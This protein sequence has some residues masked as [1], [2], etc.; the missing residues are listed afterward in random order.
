MDPAKRLE[1][2]R[3]IMGTGDERAIPVLIDCLAALKRLGKTP[4]R[5]YRAKAIIPN[6]TAPPEFWGLYV[7]TTKDFDLDIDKWSA[8]Y[9]SQRGR[10]A[11]TAATA[12][13]C[14]DS[15][16]KLP[17]ELGSS[18]PAQNILVGSRSPLAHL[19]ECLTLLK[20]GDPMDSSE[21]WGIISKALTQV[22][23]KRRED[24]VSP[25]RERYP[26]WHILKILLWCT[27][28]DVAPWVLYE[29]LKSTQGF[30]RKQGLPTNL[31]SLSQYK[32]RVKKPG[33]QRALLEFLQWSGA[34]AL[35][36]LGPQEVQIVAMDLTRLESRRGRDSKAAWG[37]DSRGF[38]F[39]YK[40]GLITSQQG[41]ILGLTLMKANYTE[42]K[43]N[44][45]LIR[46]AKETIQT[47]FATVPV[48]YLVCDAGFDGEKTY[49]ASHHQLHAPALCPPKRQRSSKAK[50]AQVILERAQRR[51]PFRYRD[52]QL[53]ATAEARELYRKRN[54]IEQV[55]G[56][57]KEAPFRIAEIPRRQRG[58]RRLLSRCLAKAL[59]FNLAIMAN[60]AAGRPTRQI[61]LW[62]A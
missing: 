39:G 54:V 4:D 29:K 17:H 58:V 31:I 44:T 8:W 24:G 49:E 48:E 34:R 22:A 47:A 61:R 60:V 36:A 9:D 21:L 40:L 12:A 51:S 43:V 32:K 19:Y 52:H 35:N 18:E 10:L 7:L 5:V 28:M 6:E 57:L 42:F 20:K 62:A 3:Q 2:V 16:T 56:Q 23:R 13:S 14:R 38:F 27:L 11:W 59:I 53:W 33:V 41:V 45:R 26:V 15:R 50:N 37:K 1:L 25:L 46:M 30:R 55:N